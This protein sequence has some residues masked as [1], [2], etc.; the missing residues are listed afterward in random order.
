MK[1]QDM[2]YERPDLQAYTETIK[3]ATEAMKGAGS[4]AE[5]RKAYFDLQAAEEQVETLYSIASVRNT[6]DT[7]DEFYE[8]EIKW[9]QEQMARLTPLNKAWQEALAGCPFREDF[10]REFGP[11][12]FRQVDAELKLTD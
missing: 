4:Y 1:F 6:I 3:G 10:I 9:L 7:R 5:A 12:L 11:Q 8:G 2:P